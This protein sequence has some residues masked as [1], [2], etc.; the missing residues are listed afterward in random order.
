MNQL[1]GISMMLF[2]NCWNKGAQDRGA[3][4]KDLIFPLMVNK[5][6]TTANEFT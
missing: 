3:T 5:N 2:K 4:T 1:F 6:V